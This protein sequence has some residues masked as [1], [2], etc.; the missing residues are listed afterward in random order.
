[1]S[2]DPYVTI[3]CEDYNCK[4]SSNYDGTLRHCFAIFVLAS[5]SVAQRMEYSHEPK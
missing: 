5:V 3:S 1:M 4:N 2:K